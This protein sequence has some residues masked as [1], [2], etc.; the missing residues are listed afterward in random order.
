[1][2]YAHFLLCLSDMKSLSYQLNITLTWSQWKL[3][4]FLFLFS[5]NNFVISWNPS[6]LNTSLIMFKSRAWHCA[7]KGPKP[8]R[9]LGGK[10]LIIIL[11][12]L[13]WVRSRSIRSRGEAGAHVTLEAYESR[14]YLFIYLFINWNL[15][16][17][18]Y[19]LAR[20]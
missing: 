9:I 4:C 14:N 10:K 19:V 18:I 2:L 11:S 1:M 13:W 3:L 12:V 15:P 16:M 7:R 5:Y 6:L 20:K 8:I 17:S